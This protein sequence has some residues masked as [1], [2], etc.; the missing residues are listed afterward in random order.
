MNNVQD[1]VHSDP[2][3]LETRGVS[4]SYPGLI[5]VDSVDFNLLA[6]EIHG[7]VGA[8]G[9]GKSSLTKLLIGAIRPDSGEI[10]FEKKKVSF[11]SPRESINLGIAGIHQELA[12]V[13]DMSVLSNVFLG[14]LITKNVFFDKSA[15][16]ARFEEISKQLDLTIQ[17]ESKVG[18]LSVA[19]RQMVEIMRAVQ[20]RRKVLIMDEPTAALGQDDRQRLY[21]LVEQLAKSG[22]SII[23]ISHDLEEVLKVCARISVMRD[24]LLV[25]TN[26]S[27]KW[28]SDSLVLAMSGES[29]KKSANRGNR[30]L[31]SVMFRAEDV[32][33]PGRVHGIECDVRRGEILGIA[34]LVGSGRSE[35]L[36]ALIGA[37]KGASGRIEVNG[38]NHNLPR[39]V[40][41]A[42]KLGIVMVPEDR[43]GQGLLMDSSAYFNISLGNADLFSKFGFFNP[44]QLR[45][46]IQSIAK[47][48]RLLTGRLHGTV[49]K[50]SGGNQ[51]KV[52][53][54]RWLVRHPSVLLLDEPSRG[55]DV[56]ARM[57][58]YETISNLAAQGVCIILVS[59]DINEIIQYS[60]R[61]LVM[62]NGRKVGLLSRDEVDLESVLKLNFAL[63]PEVK[64]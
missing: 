41:Q 63:D 43:R 4:K 17:P 40:R 59:S 15:M 60:D 6:G 7:L 54:A 26:D 55:V 44:S 9:A 21:E 14:N 37:E 8:N 11:R 32:C 57:E 13:P 25:E 35:F 52:L 19:G 33:V 3:L 64:S 47:D 48:V 22:T 58:I 51:Q 45:Q 5:A 61:V 1:V 34:G 49:N 2:P 42:M 56:S 28:T 53:L 10:Y 30:S 16:L 36:R 23:F 39:N 20:A 38:E 24:G 29:E 50:L 27:D 31:G 46:R 62:Q 12:M 18:A